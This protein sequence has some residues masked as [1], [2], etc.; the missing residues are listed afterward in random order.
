MN[1]VI[2]RQMQD[3]TQRIQMCLVMQGECA[4][5]EP[6][7]GFTLASPELTRPRSYKHRRNSYVRTDFQ[8]RQLRA[9]LIPVMESF[10]HP[11]GGTLARDIHIANLRLQVAVEGQDIS[12]IEREIT[13]MRQILDGIEDVCVAERERIALMAMHREP[14]DELV[15]MKLMTQLAEEYRK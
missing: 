9:S 4:D 7:D 14:N 6:M 11:E 8:V 13:T 1:D 2:S 15:R 10:L 5:E 3:P 12:G